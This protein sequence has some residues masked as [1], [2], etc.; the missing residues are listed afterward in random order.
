MRRRNFLWLGAAYMAL[1]RSAYTAPKRVV[2]VGSGIA[3]AIAAY[4]LHK[5]GF[6]VIVCEAAAV[7]GGRT[8]SLW[9]KQAVYELGTV[10]FLPNYHVTYRYID[11]LGL[12]A[13]L[14]NAACQDVH[15]EAGWVND[16][17]QAFAATLT[18]KQNLLK[19]KDGNGELIQQLLRPCQ[20]NLNTTVLNIEHRGSTLAI[21]TSQGRLTSEGI[22]VAV[23]VA[24][25]IKLYP[26]WAKLLQSADYVSAYV[27]ALHTTIPTRQ[28][29]SC[30]FVTD[31][32][33]YDLSYAEQL[34]YYWGNSA[35]TQPLLLQQGTHW[36]QQFLTATSTVVHQRL[37]AHA[38]PR[39]SQG[40]SALR[41][42]MHAWQQ[43]Y[44][45]LA[46]AGDVFVGNNFES[47]AQSGLNAAS[48]LI[49]NLG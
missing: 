49:N 7:L 37:Y 31:G 43:R 48:R 24:G 35:A 6:T 14:N 12:T 2:V 29:L 1:P 26:A 47:A 5:H 19:L 44:P 22:V 36:L 46:F 23:D 17:N 39:H 8:L 38:W 40:L 3:A 9:G 20:V 41:S 34:A 4:E 15:F 25:L 13:K 32:L 42:A 27:A 30:R 33:L 16:I 11:Q 45:H 28:P 10:Y 21:E 18:A